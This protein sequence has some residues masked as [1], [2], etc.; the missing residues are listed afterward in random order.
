MATTVLAHL[1]S[2]LPQK[3]NLAT[4]ALAFI[5]NRSARARQALAAEVLQLTGRALLLERVEAQV[6][7][8]EEGRPDLRLLD[9]VGGLLGFVEAKFW[10]GLT[11]AQPVAYLRHL[12]ETGG[13]VLVVL[14]PDR[15]LSMLRAELLDR[16]RHAEMGMEAVGA[17]SLRVGP[18]DLIMVPWNRLLRVVAHAV[19]DDLAVASDV[20]QLAGLVT[21]F[22]EDGFLPLTREELDDIAVPRRVA[23][24]SALV[25]DIVQSALD[26]QLLTVRNLR[27]SSSVDGIGR[28]VAFARAGAW[29]GLSF[30]CWRTRGRSP[31]WLRF[32]PT[33]WGRAD[34]L[35][36]VLQSW[37]VLD[38]PRASA[39]MARTEAAAPT[40]E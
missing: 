12:A 18:V 17:S 36:W 22:E 32:R 38:P 24:L 4:G 13:G 14:A 21:R 5:L 34:E 23:D 25:G 39:G 29:I 16:C 9:G 27:P 3:E 28:Y 2:D 30:W 7:L 6:A 20:Q 40:D 1:A 26:A 10:A 37:S 8:D 19:A 33:V 15:R 11:E 31:L 35:R